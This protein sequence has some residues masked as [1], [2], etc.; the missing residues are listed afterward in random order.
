MHCMYC[1][2]RI[3]IPV[4]T[5]VPTFCQYR[6]GIGTERQRK[7]IVDGGNRSS[8]AEI[9]HRQSILAVPPGSDRSVYRSV[10][11]TGM[12]WAVW[13][14]PLGKENLAAR[15]RVPYRTEINSVC[16]YGLV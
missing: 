8:T 11:Q 16:R 9:D 7:S 14:L 15:Y 13:V 1:S 12:Y 3:D 5:G 4:R 10:C 6:Y 2:A